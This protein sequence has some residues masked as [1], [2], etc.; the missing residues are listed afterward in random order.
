MGIKKPPKTVKMIIWL[1]TRSGNREMHLGDLEEEYSFIYSEKGKLK[2]NLW[3][4]SQIFLPLIT[5][6]CNYIFWSLTMFKNYLKIALRNIRNQKVYSFIN[7]SGL[8]AG[9]ACCIL[10]LLW[11]QYEFSYDNF[12]QNGDR[13]YRVIQQPGS[14]VFMSATPTYTPDPMGPELTNRF[15]EIDDYCRNYYLFYDH[16]VQYNEFVDF[17]NKSYIVDQSF[18]EIFNFE[19]RR[20]NPLN[21]LDK[22]NSVVITEKTAVRYFGSEDPVGKNILFEDGKY[23]LEVT[24]IIKDIPENSQMY[25]DFIL[26]LDALERIYSDWWKSD[27]TEW[28]DQNVMTYLL[29][30]EN[31]SQYEFEEKLN[32]YIKVNTEIPELEFFLQPLK[33]AHLYSDFP[34]DPA[35]RGRI[36]INNIYFFLIISV[37]VLLIACINFMNLSTARSLKRSK[38]VG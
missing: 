10:T 11:V 23:V 5:I 2:A 3:Y 17:Q 4:L 7:I 33:K 35:N 12:H 28:K 36:S 37:S 31:F 26:R 24:G 25:F 16:R 34:R 21:A 14:N 32:N 8:A 1:L 19:F 13:I 18:F 22:L 9:L 29:T 6:L 30:S 20:G 15:P 27:F 38:E